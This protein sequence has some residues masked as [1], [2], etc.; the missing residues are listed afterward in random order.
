MQRLDTLCINYTST[1]EARVR[2]SRQ[3][4]RPLG[5]CSPRVPVDSCTEIKPL[6]RGDFINYFRSLGAKYRM[7]SCVSA[8]PKRWLLRLEN[9]RP[10]DICTRQQVQA[11]VPSGGSLSFSKSGAPRTIRLHHNSEYG[12]PP[13][14]SS[15]HDRLDV[16]NWEIY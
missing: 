7:P 9:S 12:W 10:H 13:T 15:I 16:T 2:D 8:P 6:F 11:M 4:S 3:G 1:P 14:S 5:L